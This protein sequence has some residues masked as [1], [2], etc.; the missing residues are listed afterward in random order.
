MDEERLHTI[1]AV[2]DDLAKID[3]PIEDTLRCFL[4][5][6]DIFGDS[7]TEPA[8]DLTNPAQHEAECVW[9]RAIE[10]RSDPS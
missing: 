6:R 4:C 1:T 8:T 2:V 10:L 3:P 9:R 7:E 5:G